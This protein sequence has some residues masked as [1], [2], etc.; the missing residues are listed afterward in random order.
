MQ[1]NQGF[2]LEEFVGSLP[3][4]LERAVLRVLGFHQGRDQAIGRRDL[5]AAVAQ[6]GFVVHE[7]ALRAQINELRKEGHPICSTGGEDGGYW[8]AANWDELNEFAD[9]ELHSRA[10]DLLEVERALREAGERRWGQYSSGKQIP[11]F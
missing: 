10:M 3:M 9:R 5:L 2:D 6:H 11:M 8:M 1:L 4:G 7:R